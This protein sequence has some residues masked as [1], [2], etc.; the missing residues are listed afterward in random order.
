M[1]KALKTLCKEIKANMT[2]PQLTSHS[3]MGGLKHVPKIRSRTRMPTLA[4]SI[5]NGAE[6]T[7]E[8]SDTRKR[9]KKGFKLEKEVKLYVC[10]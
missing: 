2:N 4:I 10:L 7:Q 6:S 9:N 1:T 5:H 3:M 8:S